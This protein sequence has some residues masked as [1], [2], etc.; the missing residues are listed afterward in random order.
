MFTKIIQCMMHAFEK[1]FPPQS[2]KRAFLS[3]QYHLFPVRPHISQDVCP[4]V[5]LRPSQPPS[6]FLRGPCR[7]YHQ[8]IVLRITYLMSVSPSG[9]GT[10]SL[11][12]PLS[13]PPPV[14]CWAEQNPLFT[15]RRKKENRSWKTDHKFPR[16]EHRKRYVFECQD[17]AEKEI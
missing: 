14:Y 3:V 11:C 10:M 13:P 15:D 16:P 8:A 4:C 7:V 2:F 5:C 1:I 12:L 6:L 17:R 9:A